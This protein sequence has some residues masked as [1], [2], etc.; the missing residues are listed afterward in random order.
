MRDGDG[1]DDVGCENDVVVWMKTIVIM[2]LTATVA[3]VERSVPKSVHFSRASTKVA[4]NDA[5]ITQIVPGEI[6][7]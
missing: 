3:V 4:R 6:A 1:D 7:T 2:L 5:C